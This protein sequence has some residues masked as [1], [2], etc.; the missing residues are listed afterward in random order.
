MSNL[1]NLTPNDNDNGITEEFKNSGLYDPNRTSP[2]APINPNKIINPYKN[3]LNSKI[4]HFYLKLF[5]LYYTK[6][7]N[8]KKSI[9]E[10]YFLEYFKFLHVENIPNLYEYDNLVQK[11]GIPDILNPYE[12]ATI[13]YEYYGQPH[14]LG[15]D[16]ENILYYMIY[17]S[18]LEEQNKILENM[19]TQ[20]YCEQVLNHGLKNTLLDLKTTKE[21]YINSIHII[22]I[23]LQHAKCLNDF[24]N[25][26]EI[27][28]F[29]NIRNVFQEVFFNIDLKYYPLINLQKI[30]ENLIKFK[31]F[32]QKEIDFFKRIKISNEKHLNK[33][34]DESNK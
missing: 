26:L 24:E 18:S 19:N 8:S 21:I 11:F 15:R 27:V 22:A 25:L 34:N 1:Y 31:F 2:F 12:P 20:D 23:T 32:S 30:E 28:D 9:K 10:A 16:I 5:N 4:Y 13:E 7:L 33:Q 6:F 29:S 14:I 17:K 3:K